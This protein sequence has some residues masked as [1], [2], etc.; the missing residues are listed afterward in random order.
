[1]YYMAESRLL[2]H[3]MSLFK[4]PYIIWVYV[5]MRKEIKSEGFKYCEYI[6]VYVDDLLILSHQTNVIVDVIKGM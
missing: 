5:W 6:L 4:I 2:L 1:M 3:G